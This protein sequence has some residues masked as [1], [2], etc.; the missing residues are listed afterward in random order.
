MKRFFRTAGFIHLKTGFYTLLLVLF[1]PSCATVLLKKDYSVNISSD[2]P[3]S[4][5]AVSDTVYDLPARIK[6]KIKKQTV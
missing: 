6:I 4:K 1:L 3:G 2:L 5:V